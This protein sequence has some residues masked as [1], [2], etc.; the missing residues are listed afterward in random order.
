M[1]TYSTSRPSRPIR[2]S[3]A[4]M[5]TDPS[6]VADCSFKPPPRR[7]NGVRTAETMTVRLTPLNLLG[8]VDCAVV[9]H[10]AAVVVVDRD[11]VE[12]AQHVRAE[13]PL[14][15]AVRIPERKV[16]LD[17]RRRRQRHAP[18]APAL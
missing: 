9:Q 3:A 16:G 15:A 5:T 6:C 12:L 2:S 4:R 13:E 17:D 1:I 7:P 10:E 8:R 18:H 14:N 11:D